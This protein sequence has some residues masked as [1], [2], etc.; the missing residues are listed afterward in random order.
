MANSKWVLSGVLLLTGCGGG[1]KPAA[2]EKAIP[3]EPVKIV[4]FYAAEPMASL[5]APARLCYGVE[6]AQSVKLTPPVEQVWPAVSRCFNVNPRVATRF[7]LTAV[8]KD[9]SEVTKSLELKIGKK[10]EPPAVAEGGG[11]QVLF[12]LSPSPEIPAGFPSTICYGVSGAT[13]V[14]ME[15]L[16]PD[17]KATAK[18]CATVRPEKT[19][20]YTLTATDAAGRADRQTITIKVK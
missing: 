1:Q 5:D 10:V 12:L 3:V 16:V 2:N 7:T 14:S 15:P 17:L 18:F 8:G 13:K 11:P 9:G 4:S 6:N 19:T 20:T